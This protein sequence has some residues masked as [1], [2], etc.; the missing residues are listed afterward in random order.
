MDNVPQKLVLQ[1]PV[2]K[3]LMTKGEDIEA[4][5]YIAA[6]GWEI[7]YNPKMHIY[8]YIPKNRF[9]REYLI[10]FFK[11]V[12]LSRHR[13]RMLNYKPWQKPLIFPAYFVNDLRKLILHFWKYRDVLETDVVAAA[14][15]QFLQSCLVSPFFI[16]KKMYLK[17]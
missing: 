14:Q 6:A 3:S 1:G 17:K 12:G 2:G 13:T 11:G 9:E 10:K 7:W 16:W 15:F 5:S 8:H 4:L